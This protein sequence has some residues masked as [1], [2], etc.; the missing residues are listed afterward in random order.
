MFLPWMNWIFAIFIALVLAIVCLVFLSRK[1]MKQIEPK[2]KQAQAFAE[3]RQFP[4]AIKILEEILPLSKWQVMLKSQVHSQIGVFYYA[5]KKEELALQNLEKGSARSPDAQMILAS[6]FYRKKMMDKVKKVMETAIKYNKKQVVLYNALAF[7]YANGN[8]VEDAMAIL[9]KCLKKNKDN[10]TTTDNLLRLQ[11]GKKMNMKSFGMT[12][13]S[14]QL[15]KAPMSMM[16]GQF[17]GRPGFRQSK[18]MR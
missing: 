13:Y 2:F 11:N 10:E 15:E 6:I 17:A 18:K 4:Q 5:Q 8:M 9:K 1:I 7:M 3:K 16:Q 14:L 12:W